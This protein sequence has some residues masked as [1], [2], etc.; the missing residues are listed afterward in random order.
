MDNTYLKKDME[1]T[2]AS[3]RDSRDDN[4]VTEGFGP[5]RKLHCGIR[6]QLPGFLCG[7]LETGR[8]ELSSSF[9]VWGPLF[10]SILLS[11]LLIVFYLVQGE[12]SIQRVGMVGSLFCMSAFLIIT[13]TA[14]LGQQMCSRNAMNL[15]K[16]F[17][18]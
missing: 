6:F 13:G 3:S 7:C 16:K 5:D 11:P 17:G 4:D 12:S 1:D 15:G 10:A 9:S 18:C 2:T 8:L 14:I